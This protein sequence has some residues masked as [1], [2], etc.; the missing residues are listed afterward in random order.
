ML[1]NFACAA[2]YTLW[3]AGIA[4]GDISPSNIMVRNGKPFLVDFG[5]SILLDGATL[6]PRT[7]AAQQG[8]LTVSLSS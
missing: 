1:I 5:G 8:P 7:D 6:G 4:H 3:R 2:Y